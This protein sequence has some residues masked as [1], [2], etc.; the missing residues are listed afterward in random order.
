VKK[1]VEKKQKKIKN[2]TVGLRRW[3]QIIHKRKEEK[4]KDKTIETK[5]TQ[6]TTEHICLLSFPVSPFSSKCL[7]LFLPDT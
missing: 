6:K 3:K 7:P 5:Q 2:K 1:K 4:K